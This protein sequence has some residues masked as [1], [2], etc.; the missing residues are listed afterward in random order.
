MKLPVSSSDLSLPVSKGLAKDEVPEDIRAFFGHPLTAATSALEGGE[1][2][3]SALALLHEYQNLPAIDRADL[4]IGDRYESIQ[5]ILRL[6]NWW[7][8]E[9]KT[10]SALLTRCVD[11]WCIPIAK[12]Q[13]VEFFVDELATDDS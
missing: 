4:R 10:L 2:Q 11:H 9:M 7:C 6:V 13:D 5:D 8:H 3:A 12:D 1:T